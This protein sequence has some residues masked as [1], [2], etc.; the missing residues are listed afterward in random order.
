MTP[1]KWVPIALLVLTLFLAGC[2]LGGQ[3]VGTRSVSQNAPGTASNEPISQPQPPLLEPDPLSILTSQPVTG[4]VQSPIE[5]ET[6][7]SQINPSVNEPL[8]GKPK[9]AV[10]DLIAKGLLVQLP[11]PPVAAYFAA[12]LQEGKTQPQAEQLGIDYLK[13]IEDEHQSFLKKVPQAKIL[14]EFKRAFN[15][16][17]V[18][19]N[20]AAI[21]D[22]LKVSGVKIFPNRIKKANLMD[23]V[24]LIGAT[25]T[26][27]SGYKGTGLKI[28]VLDTGVDYS[29][30]DFGSC[31]TFQSCPKFVDGYDF[32]NSDSDPQDDHGHGTHVSGIVAS[33]GNLKG[34]AP[35][36]SLGAYKILS[37]EGYGDDD[38]I[39]AAIE[40]SIDPNNDGNFADRFDVISMSIGGYGTPDDPL[41]QA[42]DNANDA[43]ALV[44]V[45]A[46]NFWSGSEYGDLDCPGCA[47]KAFT[48]GATDKQDKITYFS[49]KGPLLYNQEMIAKPDI[50]A[51]GQRICSSDAYENYP[52][53][54]FDDRHLTLSG[55]S[56]A[57][58]HISGVAALIKQKYPNRSPDELKAILTESA[59]DIGN[60]V[61]TQGG[62]R[63]D[64]FKPLGLQ[65]FVMPHILNWGVITPATNRKSFNFDIIKNQ[66]GAMGAMAKV[67][68]VRN[69]DTGDT[70][71]FDSTQK[72]FCFQQNDTKKTLQYSIDFS[73]LPTGNY[74][75]YMEV[76]LYTGCDGPS[77]E[78]QTIRV[79]VAFVKLYPLTVSF[80]GTPPTG[81]NYFIHHTNLISFT[82]EDGKVKKYWFYE[83]GQ[84][85]VYNYTIYSSEKK[86]D[87][88]GLMIEN[89]YHSAYDRLNI[90]Y[91]IDNLDL[92]SVNTYAFTEEKAKHVQQNIV[93][94][95][96]SKNMVI[97]GFKTELSKKSDYYSDNLYYFHPTA[98]SFKQIDFGLYAS[99]NI[100]GLFNKD[101]W[102]IFA[103]RAID[104]GS[105]FVTTQN[106]MI[107]PFTISYPFTNL[108]KVIDPADLKFFPLQIPKTLTDYFSANQYFGIGTYSPLNYWSDPD[109]QKIGLPKNGIFYYLD[110]CEECHYHFRTYIDETNKSDN[111]YIFSNYF[112][113]PAKYIPETTGKKPSKV[114]FFAEPLSLGLSNS[115]CVQASPGKYRFCGDDVLRGFL[116]DEFN[117]KSHL[118]TEGYSGKLIIKT[119]SGKSHSIFSGDNQILAFGRFGSWIIDCTNKWLSVPK[120]TLN[121]PDFCQDGL[122]EISWEMPDVI[123]G[124]TLTLNA[125]V[126]HKNNQFILPSNIFPSKC[127]TGWEYFEQID[128]CVFNGYKQK[129]DYSNAVSFCQGKGGWLPKA[130][131]LNPICNQFDLRSGEICG[132]GYNCM[133]SVRVTDPYATGHKLWHD[134]GYHFTNEACGQ[135]IYDFCGTQYKNPS[136]QWVEGWLQDSRTDYGFV[137]LKNPA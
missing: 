69:I 113:G 46:G 126:E 60:D 104:N 19:E 45:A 135:V 49:G 84:E 6:R 74:S 72:Q 88:A 24:P 112:D 59:V 2:A 106:N 87:L 31:T 9:E 27:K 61:F 110:D 57:T 29:H 58:P 63:V 13:K 130:S 5:P 86:V 95:A 108:S 51:P 82:N 17:L 134:Q 136:C 14:R 65:A 124:K 76:D 133:G 40:R 66:Q 137:C 62:G 7:F 38:D 39:I 114:S 26:W 125:V 20:H 44:V 73:E 1:K 123:K 115:H 118:T 98:G 28:A 33:D 22:I 91:F 43:G 52:S 70:Y 67:T 48:V 23:S 15:G 109:A 99:G 127:E 77:T 32:V 18:E 64:A 122:Y 54:C 85:N 102:I 81:N 107:L 36:A 10:D 30:P 89:A 50:V 96:D 100:N 120:K 83:Y 117:A 53:D 131:E 4:N 3:G 35:K 111:Y 41:S 47:R 94:T 55:T 92:N 79:P 90:N 116:K 68:T 75:G 37:A 71:S 119:P 42:V 103:P 80:H 16:F 105:T 132:G 56:M 93:E 128:K 12:T 129:M 121:D 34:V 8:I 78:V 11:S 97:N 101:F 21:N 25:N